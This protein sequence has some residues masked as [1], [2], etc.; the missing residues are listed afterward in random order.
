VDD[1]RQHAGPVKT[2]FRRCSWRECFGRSDALTGTAFVLVVTTAAGSAA[3]YS[4][5]HGYRSVGSV[6]CMT[7]VVRAI[8]CNGIT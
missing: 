3:G 5:S 1:L 8:W 2:S 7:Y 4:G 6:D